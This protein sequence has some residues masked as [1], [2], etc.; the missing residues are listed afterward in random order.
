[1]CRSSLPG[2]REVSFH[3]PRGQQ[4]HLG[5]ERVEVRRSQ[6]YAEIAEV[7][8]TAFAS[9]PAHATHGRL[10]VRRVRDLNPTAAEGSS[11]G[12]DQC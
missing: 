10:I 2:C 8:Y 9:S 1:M 12:S 7:P 6:P 11:T 3:P 5:I 4:P